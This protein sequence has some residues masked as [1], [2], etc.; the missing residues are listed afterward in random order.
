METDRPGE[1]HETTARL[2]T[3]RLSKLLLRLSTP[4]MISMIAMSF[5]GLA[6]TFWLG[7]LGYNAVAAVT[8]T[9][10]LYNV[11][12]AIGL[13]SGVGA[14]ALASKRFGER[15]IEETNRV[16]GQVFFLTAVF[17]LISVIATVGLARPLAALLGAPPQVI[18]LTVQYLVFFGWGIPFI[19][20][21]LMTRNIFHASGDVTNP[22]IFIIAGS[23][24]NAA[25]DPFLIFGW[26]PFPAMGV[27]GAGLATTIGGGLTAALSAYHLVNGRS[28]YRLKLHHLKPDITIIAQIYRV[29]L[30]S[31]LMDLVEAFIFLVL[32]RTIAGFGSVALAAL[33]VAG[34]VA[35]L[36]FIPVVGVGHALLPIVGFCLGARLWQRLWAAIRQ[37]VLISAAVLG[38]A[39]LLLA[40]FA[41]RIIALF[42]N[43]PELLAVAVPGM[44]IFTSAFVLV[45]PAIMFTVAFQ[46]LSR[47]WTAISLSLVRQL[48]V[49]LPAVLVLPR[50]LGLTGAWLAMPISDAAGAIVGGLWLYREYR[51]QKRTGI[52]EKLPPAEPALASTPG[53]CPETD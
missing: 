2:G 12:F 50:C 53:D 30:P 39:S 47:G 51:L 32:N 43:N 10:P 52:W 21:R 16:A 18:D 38:G 5:Y 13:G 45:G 24:L 7:R 33:G 48:I 42:N 40:I 8:V 3:E 37:S 23:V 35:D 36:A 6:D 34:R 11:A 15:N 31:V 29:G 44:R 41:P 17:G 14:N 9:F 49:F 19:L 1:L 26:G 27:G 28:V 20:F 25:L 46:G 4:S 22:M